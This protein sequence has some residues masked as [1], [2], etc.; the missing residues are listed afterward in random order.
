MQVVVPLDHDA[1]DTWLCICGFCKSTKHDF[2]YLVNV[3][4]QQIYLRLNINRSIIYWKLKCGK[5][6]MQT[7][8]NAFFLVISS[9]STCNLSSHC[10]TAT[11]KLPVLPPVWHIKMEVSRYLRTQQPNL[12]SFSSHYPFRVKLPEEKFEYRFLK[13]YVFSKVLCFS[14]LFVC[15]FMFLLFSK[16]LYSFCSL[17]FAQTAFSYPIYTSPKFKSRFLYIFWPRPLFLNLFCLSSIRIL[18]RF[19]CLCLSIVFS[20]CI[21]FP[22]GRK[23]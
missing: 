17:K 16:V 1:N 12:L 9:N 19:F 3:T 7:I 14:F 5:L 13:S 18:H 2:L 23:G 15:C 20:V 22:T 10:A 4:K 6:K 21:V 11:S 8:K